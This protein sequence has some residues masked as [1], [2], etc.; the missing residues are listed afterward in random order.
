MSS[1]LSMTT[2]SHQ[3][4]RIF[5]V[6]MARAILWV[7]W[8]LGLLMWVPRVENVFQR[9]NLRPGSSAQ[10]VISLTHGLVPLG[11]LLVL[12]FIALDGAVSYRLHRVI[13]RALWSGLMTIAPIA[14]MILTAIVISRP[15][16]LALEFITK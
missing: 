12:A 13:A 4:P 15:M 3:L 16:L 7:A 5:L 11:L 10:F 6:L 9:L 1:I 2:S 8:L 14:V